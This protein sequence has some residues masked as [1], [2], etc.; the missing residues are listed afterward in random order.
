MSMYIIYYI[1]SADTS[2][3]ENVGV[4]RSFRIKLRLFAEGEPLGGHY[5]VH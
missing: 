1:P 4:S 5:V 2:V 3:Q